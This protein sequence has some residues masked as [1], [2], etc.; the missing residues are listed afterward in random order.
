MAESSDHDSM[1]K[2]FLLVLGPILCW[3]A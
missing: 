1:A 2:E 3:N